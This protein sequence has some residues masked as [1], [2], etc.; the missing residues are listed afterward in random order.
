MRQGFV[1]SST[2]VLVPSVA[3]NVAS[4]PRIVTGKELLMAP[5]GM[6]QMDPVVEPPAIDKVKPT[7]TPAEGAGV[8]SLTVQVTTFEPLEHSSPANCGLEGNSVT[9]LESV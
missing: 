2:V 9:M 3:V 5:D 1:F 4:A 7:S 8:V 6:C